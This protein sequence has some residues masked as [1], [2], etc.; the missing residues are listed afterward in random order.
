MVAEAQQSSIF[1]QT[2]QDYSDW[3]AQVIRAA[4]YPDQVIRNTLTAPQSLSHKLEEMVH[5]GR[6]ARAVIEEVLD[7]Q[8]DLHAHAQS[9]LAS[10]DRPPLKVFDE[11][12][13]LYEDFHDRL[14]RFDIDS[15]LSDF[16]LDASTGLRSTI[17]MMADLERE[18]ERR[19]RRGH[20]FSIVMCQIDNPQA[21]TLADNIQSAAKAFKLCMRSF[22]DAYL[23]ARNE[24]L[25]CLKQTDNAGALRFVE[26]LKYTLANQKV[27]FTMSYCAAE[28]MPGEDMPALISNVRADLKTIASSGKGESGE[29]DEISP[30]QRFVKNKLTDV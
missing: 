13:R 30:L 26:R 12:L 17:V 24:M 2:L 20:P 6:L 19:A 5:D 18:L 14:E 15:L 25:I 21:E 28:P 29:Y 8:K 3:F 27:K 11:F 16:G 23:S 1:Y 10:S 4:F 7:R 9:M 22:D